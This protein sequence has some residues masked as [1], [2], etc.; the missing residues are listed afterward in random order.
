MKSARIEA[1]GK[2]VIADVCEPRIEAPDDIK[3]RIDYAAICADDLFSFRK[4]FFHDHTAMLGHEFSGTVAEVGSK[5]RESNLVPGSRVSGYVWNFCGNCHYCRSG[6][7]NICI[8][9]DWKGAFQEYGVFKERQLGLLPQSVSHLHGCFT[10][11][12]S[13]G[14]HS[15]DR[16]GL[17]PGQTLLILGAGG[18]GLVTLQLARLYGASKITVSEPMASKRELAS[19][20]GADHVIDPT[21]ESLNKRGMEITEQLGYDVIIDTAHDG[22]AMQHVITILGRGGT[23]ML[24]AL[25]DN[26]IQLSLRP[27]TAYAKEQTILTSFIAP[28]MLDRVMNVLPRLDL[29]ALI[30]KVYRFDQVQEAFEACSESLWPRV[31]IDI[32][33]QADRSRL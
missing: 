27:S 16:I 19:S 5:A 29:G 6:R 25:Y 10:E 20:F 17:R 21:R 3:V 2:I 1:P 32:S 22:E 13:S 26:E 33:G 14:M 30:G 15:L 11:L 12:V 7:E 8:D 31:V 9:L 18:A 24:Y 23:L 4:K 28:Y